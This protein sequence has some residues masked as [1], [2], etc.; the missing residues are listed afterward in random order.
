MTTNFAVTND[1]NWVSDSVSLFERFSNQDN[2]QWI[3]LNLQKLFQYAFQLP[4]ETVFDL[5]QFLESIG[6]VKDDFD[7]KTGDFLNSDIFTYLT[8]PKGVL[9]FNFYNKNQEALTPQYNTDDDTISFYFNEQPVP[10]KDVL[11]NFVRK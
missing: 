7:E 1:E 5:H 4:K 8:S 11:M 3:K 10:E 2:P 6:I 9:T